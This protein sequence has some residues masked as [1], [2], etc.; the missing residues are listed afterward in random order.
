MPLISLLIYIV[1]FAIVAYGLYWICVKFQLPQ[2]VMWICGALLL[3]VLLLF[4]ANQLGVSG[5]V[6][7]PTRR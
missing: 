4:L 6:N 2:P 5:S 3:I 1:I 7:L